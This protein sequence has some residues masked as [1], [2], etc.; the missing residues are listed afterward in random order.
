ML[1]GLLGK[2]S[3]ITLLGGAVFGGVSLAKTQSSSSSVSSKTT[4]SSPESSG[5]VRLS[6]L[7]EYKK[8]CQVLMSLTKDED[9][10]TR[11]VFVCKVFENNSAKDI[12]VY[13]YKDQSTPIKKIES[14]S[15]QV[16]ERNTIGTVT[17][18]YQGSGED[19][20]SQEDM[21]ISQNSNWDKLHGV[22]LEEKCFVDW[23]N[24]YKRMDFRDTEFFWVLKSVSQSIGLDSE[25]Y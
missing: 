13:L 23:S 22:K 15:Y 10:I 25:E 9:E 17:F 21:R 1:L 7:E 16:P 11:H 12:G 6:N 4:S 18:K 3:G 8:N 24:D 14:L 20:Q 19:S 5:K 2:F